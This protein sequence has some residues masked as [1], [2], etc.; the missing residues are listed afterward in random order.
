MI[1][2]DDITGENK[3]KHILNQPYILDNQFR[4]IINGDSG[5]GKI[6]ALLNL[7]EIKDVDDYD[8]IDKIYFYVKDPNEAKC[9]Y[10][11]IKHRKIGLDYNKNPNL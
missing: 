7:V 1:G 10:L 6:N 2:Y 9:Q 3:A 5:S 11:I 8:I 4:I